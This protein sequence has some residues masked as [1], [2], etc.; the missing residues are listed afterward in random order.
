M[1]KPSDLQIAPPVNGSQFESLCLDLYKAKFGDRTQKNGRSGQAQNGVDI[2]SPEQNVGIQCKKR[3]HGNGKITEEELKQEVEKAKQFKPALKRFIL[4]TTCKRDANIQRIARLIDREH[5]EKNL[6]SVE[7]HSWEEI[8]ELLYQYPA[9]YNK[10]YSQ[11]Q[12][13][14]SQTVFNSSLI[15]SIEGKSR[16]E[17]LNTIRDL[18]NKNQPKTAFKLLEKFEKE[19]WQGLE[20]KEKYRV[21]TNQA[22]A[23]V[24]MKKEKQASALIIKA[25]QFNKGNEENSYTNCAIAYLFYD[26]LEKA[27]EFIKNAKKLNPLNV[28]AHVVEIKIKDKEGQT[29]DEIASSLPKAIREESQIALVLSAIGI[30]E[31]QYIKAKKWLDIFYKYREQAESGDWKNIQDEANYADISLGLILE[32]PE[33]FSGRRITDNLKK[34]NEEIIKIYK[35]IVIDDKY[36]GIRKF[37]PNWF[38]Y[39]A[40]ALELNEELD[41]AIQALKMGIDNFPKN[42]TLKVELIRL[43]E[44]T[45]QIVKGIKNLEKQLDLKFFDSKNSSK[46]TLDSSKLDINKKSFNLIMMLIDLY[47]RNS[48]KEEAQE[49]LNKLEESS[50]ISENQKL[51]VK[52]EQIFRFIIFEKIEEAEKKLAPL[53]IRNQANLLIFILKSQIESLKAKKASKVQDSKNH[54]KKSIEYLREAYRLFREKYKNHD[55]PYL[56]DK[57][58][59]VDIMRLAHELYISKMYK[60]AESLVE[61][62]TNNNLNH[63]EIFKLL[64]IYFE[65]GKNEKAVELAKNLF[66]KFP[67]RIESVYTLSR[68]YEDRGDRKTAI[69]YYERFYEKNPQNSF[70]RIGLAI[71][72]INR[73]DI[74]K[75]KKLLKKDF[76]LDKLSGEQISRLSF[77]YSKTGNIRKALEILY[78]YIKRN[79]RELDSQKFYFSLIGFLN[80]Q[81]SYNLQNPDQAIGHQTDY[82][83]LQP[84]VVDIDCYVQI[85]NTQNLKTNIVIEKDADIHT[86]DHELSKALLGKRKNEIISLDSEKYEI[87]EI[88]SKYIHKWHKIAEE[89]EIQHPTKPFVKLFSIPKNAGIKDISQSFQKIKSNFF[90]QQAD[91]AKLY[92]FYNRGQ[93]TIGSIAK[94]SGQHP[95]EVIGSLIFSKNKWISAFP[96]WEKNQKTQELLNT[97]TNILVDLSAL[98]AIHQLEIEKYIE[99]SSFKFFISQS[100]IDSLTEYINK[101]SLYSKDGLLTGGFDKEDNFRTNRVNAD[102]IKK[103]LNFWIKVKTWAE[104]HCQIKILSDKIVLSRKEKQQKETVLGK[105]FFDSLL[106][107]DSNFIF[108]CEDAILRKLADIE[109]SIKGAR[110]FDLIE[111]FEKDGLIYFNQAVHFK[112]K[113]VRFNQTYIPTDHHVL[114]L[115]LKEA[116]YSVSDVGFQKALYFLSPVSH[117]KG[118]IDVISNFLIEVC[119]K[120]ALMPYRKQ[121]ITNM[122]LDQASLGRDENPKVIASHILH[123]VQIRTHLEPIL[124]EEVRRCIMEWLNIRKFQIILKKIGENCK[125]I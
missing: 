26:D 80:Q 27:K 33:I 94:I 7:I 41:E 53:F 106:A 100:T 43:F 78:Q 111:Y 12:T 24:R 3:K 91:I 70:I 37:N 125:S 50:S 52:Q 38:L 98:I 57:E 114:F 76:N 72:Y 79:P 21:L 25:L 28:I 85:K 71:A 81:N 96:Q 58:W 64:H 74:S 108:L 35:K 13:T 54:Q 115:L 109:Y 14:G 93:V 29:L 1:L 87:L 23:L 89:N 119:Q 73:G 122:V 63:P 11:F 112:A 92:E 95:I 8:K 51:R 45:G 32:K 68:I 22:S 17:K 104:N 59:L 101:S 103:D 4:A 39:Y 49:L 121:I 31:K 36:S 56:K 65:N 62:I 102:I 107:V 16:N 83:F 84:E 48:Q 40:L 42:E 118:V 90:K 67:E 5:K 18:L 123:L 34:K 120:S 6:F 30:N 116:E 46:K 20:D 113:L 44:Q 110:L 75:A 9:I 77:A 61:E 10:Y 97:T 15:K 117:L 19:K 86:P 69:Q 47:F 82:S 55:S 124:Q 88:K 2:F 60:E 105:E 66:K 99:S